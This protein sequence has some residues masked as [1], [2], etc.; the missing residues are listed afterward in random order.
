VA[1]GSLVQHAQADQLLD[2][3]RVNIAEDHRDQ[4]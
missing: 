4:L 3:A 1:A 2:R